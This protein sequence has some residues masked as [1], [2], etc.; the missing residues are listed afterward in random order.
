MITPGGQY[1]AYL[2]LATNLVPN[3]ANNAEDVFV[4][5]T[6]PNTTPIDDARFFVR[7]QYLDFL[8]REP[9]QS[10]WDYWTSQITQCANDAL[11][12][13]NQRIGVSAAFFIENEFQQTG[14]V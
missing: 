11:C 5:S 7:Q 10:G 14:Y 9:D 6:D 13:H 8:N 1:V 12:V 2:S 4:F 3:D